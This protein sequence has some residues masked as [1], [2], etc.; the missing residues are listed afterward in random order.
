MAVEAP[1]FVPLV[2]CSKLKFVSSFKGI[3]LEF[4]SWGLKPYSSWQLQIGM[5]VSWDLKYLCSN[6]PD[7]A[8]RLTLWSDTALGMAFFSGIQKTGSLLDC[9]K[10]H[11]TDYFSDN[12]RGLYV[13]WLLPWG[14]G[15]AVATSPGF[16]FSAG[17]RG[18]PL[19]SMLLLL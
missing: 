15:E 6:I 14:P 16:V 3:Y 2:S 17:A 1:N 5:T 8:V 18:Q 12:W 13:R 19:V 7:L 10:T 11:W 9:R 4:F